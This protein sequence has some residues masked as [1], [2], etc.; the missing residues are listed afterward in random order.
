MAHNRDWRTG[1]G[2]CRKYLKSE[3]CGGH[4]AGLVLF[5]VRVSGLEG[6]FVEEC[7][8]W[9]MRACVGGY[10]TTRKHNTVVAWR[11]GRLLA[12]AMLA[13]L[14]AAEVLYPR[15]IRSTD[16]RCMTTRSKAGWLRQ[17]GSLLNVDRL[18][19]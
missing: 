9:S 3:C 14:E 10:V 13:Q 2:Q 8:W 5:E 7:W 6:G 4:A 15:G 17:G 11:H 12:M 18:C 1:D 19:R 16:G